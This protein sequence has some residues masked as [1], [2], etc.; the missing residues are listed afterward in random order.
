MHSTH[1]AVKAHGA[2]VRKVNWKLVIWRYSWIHCAFYA[3]SLARLPVID[4]SSN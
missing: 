1:I 2:I 3:V 4:A